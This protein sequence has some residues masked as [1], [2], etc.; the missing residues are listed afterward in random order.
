LTARTRFNPAALEEYRETI[1]RYEAARPGLG[2]E[3]RLE[4]ETYV[5]WAAA[6]ELPGTAIASRRGHKLRRLLLHRFP[7]A[8]IFELGHDE[9]VVW[10]VAHTSRRPGFWRR[11]I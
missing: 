3:F 5:E 10:A 2:D 11:R 9:C 6:R 1:V 8:L 4:V 7:Y